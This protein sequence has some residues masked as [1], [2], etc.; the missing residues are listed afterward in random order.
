MKLCPIFLLAVMDNNTP[1]G[2]YKGED[3]L[4]DPLGW[5]LGTSS[6]QHGDISPPAIPLGF[7]S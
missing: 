7:L 1:K 5:G 4:L 2:L 3:T 6:E